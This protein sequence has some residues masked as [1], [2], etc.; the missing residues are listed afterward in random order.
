MLAPLRNKA[1]RLVHT[2]TVIQVTFDKYLKLD[3]ALVDPR[4]VGTP[5][6]NSLFQTNARSEGALFLL[7][8]LSW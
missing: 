1:E 7:N 8:S 6:P 5:G 4:L 3:P 2:E